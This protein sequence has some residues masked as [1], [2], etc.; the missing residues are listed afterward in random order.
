MVPSGLVLAPGEH[1]AGRQQVHVQRHDVP[2]HRRVPLARGGFRRQRRNGDGRG[3]RGSGP[4]REPDGLRAR[5]GDP[6]IGE[7]R[8]AVRLRRRSQRALQR[9]RPVAMLAV[10]TTP[11]TTTP[12]RVFHHHDRLRAG[13]QTSRSSA[14][15]GGCLLT[16]RVAAGPAAAVIPVPASGSGVGLVGSSSPQVI[17]EPA[18]AMAS[19]SRVVRR[20]RVIDIAGRDWRWR[21]QE[22][23]QRSGRTGCRNCLKRSKLGQLANPV[24]PCLRRVRH[25]GPTD[26]A[27]RA[28]SRRQ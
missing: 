16:R 4:G 11:G 28:E 23:R 25:D 6:Q 14:L 19:S 7:R 27:P 18:R 3:G 10:T 17:E 26:T 22:A 21:T 13:P 8:G 24:A 12:A 5:A 2:G 1:L 9:P 20:K 15:A